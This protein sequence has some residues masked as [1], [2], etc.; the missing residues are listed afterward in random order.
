[1][2]RTPNFRRTSRRDQCAAI[3]Q[4]SPISKQQLTKRCEKC[5]QSSDGCVRFC[6]PKIRRKP[7]I[8][9]AALRKPNRIISI[10][11]SVSAR[12]SCRRNNTITPS[13]CSKS[14]CRSRPTI[15]RRTPIW[16]RRFSAET[17]C[18]SDKLNINGSRKNSRNWQLL[19]IFLLS[20]TT[21]WE[22]I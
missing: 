15:S 12:R 10:T 8:I 17:L 5:D 3:R 13:R 22:N 19:I 9:A 20:H 16:R 21:I 14:F 7:L 1:M 11:P 4:M 2:P 18:R 6:A